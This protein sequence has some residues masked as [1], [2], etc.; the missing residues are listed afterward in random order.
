[1]SRLGIGRFLR[2][3]L[4]VVDARVKDQ[5]TLKL[6]VFSGQDPLSKRYSLALCRRNLSS[7]EANFTGHDS[8]IVPVLA[9]LGVYEDV[10][11]PY[12][13][14]IVIEVAEDTRTHRYM[15]RVLYNDAQVCTD[16]GRMPV[17]CSLEDLERLLS[18][19]I[20][21]DYEAECRCLSR[22][23]TDLSMKEDGDGVSDTITSARNGKQKSG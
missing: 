20:P 14:N 1:M 9:A 7:H 12:A 21:I 10:W 2:E 16:R 8:T 17:W 6:Q 11:P 19:Y 18:K 13:S 22:R 4:D 15:A 5:S 23:D 3:L